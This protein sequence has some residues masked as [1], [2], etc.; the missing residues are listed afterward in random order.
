[1]LS[2]AARYL[3]ENFALRHLIET[4]EAQLSE[5]RHSGP[6]FGDARVS[7]LGV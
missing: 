6:S 2:S 3:T 5:K 4:Y 1:M 7:G